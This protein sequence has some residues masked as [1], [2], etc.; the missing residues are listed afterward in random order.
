MFMKIWKVVH[1]CKVQRIINNS[2]HYRNH[3]SYVTK[4][5]EILVR[6]T[7]S[8]KRFTIIFYFQNLLSRRFGFFSF[9]QVKSVYPFFNS[10]KSIYNSIKALII[11]KVTRYTMHNF[12][13]SS[14]I[15]L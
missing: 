12:K 7:N 11:N 5:K 2:W 15:T 6:D 14:F 13:S 8:N 1:V 3:G 10:S 4:G 9:F